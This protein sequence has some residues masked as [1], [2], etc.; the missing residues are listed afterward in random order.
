LTKA[1]LIKRNQGGYSLTS[2]GRVV[3]NVNTTLEQA[4]SYYWKMKAIELIPLSLPA[5][6]SREDLTNLIKSLIDDPEIREIVTK[7]L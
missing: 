6:L 5:G 1:G 7:S 3:R 2:L 4:L